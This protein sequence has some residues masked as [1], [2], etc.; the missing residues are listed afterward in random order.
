MPLITNTILADEKTWQ[1]KF[2][3]TIFINPEDV[4]IERSTD[5]FTKGILFEHK[6][7][8]TSNGRSKTLG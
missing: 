7:N 3:E 6:Q 2:Y 5:G 8:V 1:T 4:K